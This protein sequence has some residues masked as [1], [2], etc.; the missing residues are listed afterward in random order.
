M[1]TVFT[2]IMGTDDDDSQNNCNGIARLVNDR[3]IH[4]RSMMDI[5]LRERTKMPL[6]RTE[7]IWADSQDLVTSVAISNWWRHTTPS[8]LSSFFA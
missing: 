7:D 5:T 1:S 2:P 8:L 4:D 3:R 6:E